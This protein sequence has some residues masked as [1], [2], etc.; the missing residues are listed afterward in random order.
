MRRNTDLSLLNPAIAPQNRL[1]DYH[2]LL[3]RSFNFDIHKSLMLEKKLTAVRAMAQL[4]KSGI[5]IYD[6]QKRTHIY[7]SGS[8]YQL[9]GYFK[10]HPGEVCNDVFD[11]KIHPDDLKEL[12]RNGYAALQFLMS[13][14]ARE[15]KQYKM[16]TEY[17]IRT[18]EN[19]YISVTEQH[20]ILESDAS[21][22]I[23]LS[24]G[25]LD[26]S[27]NQSEWKHVAFQIINFNT[28]EIICLEPKNQPAHHLLTAREKEILQMIGDGK[29]SKEI[30]D[31]LKISYHTVNTHRQR[32]L[33]KLK[34][35]NS[36]E[37]LDCARRLG[38][39]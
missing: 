36:I 9:Y 24:L 21:G 17:R 2:E 13:L 23:W 22:N 8:F 3:S 26:I 19:K 25:I 34:A 29:L 32:I 38:L 39:I 14:P 18:N 37:A 6:M 7:T 33:E 20:Q 31:M 35:N 1:P 27:P 11:K 28:G 5:T 30:S 16:V 10:E 4:T 12:N 15:R